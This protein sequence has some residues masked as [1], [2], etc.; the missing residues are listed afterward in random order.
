MTNL[1]ENSKEFYNATFLNCEKAVVLAN[2]LQN[3]K[4]IIAKNTEKMLH[5][6]CLYLNTR[7]LSGIGILHIVSCNIRC[8]IPETACV[9]SDRND[10]V[11]DR[12]EML[13]AEIFALL[14]NR[15]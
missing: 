10:L 1:V 3:K 13:C 14:V 15:L 6:V 9:I 7:K 8:Y 2:I 4:I 11:P 5:A 12:L